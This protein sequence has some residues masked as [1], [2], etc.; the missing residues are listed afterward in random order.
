MCGPQQSCSWTV[1]LILAWLSLSEWFGSTGVSPLFSHCSLAAQ[2]SCQW[3]TAPIS[4]ASPALFIIQYL[5]IH[6]VSLSKS[7]LTPACNQ[8]AILFLVYY[9]KHSK[10][11]ND[12][13][14]S[15]TPSE[16]EFGLHCGGW[17]VSV[18]S[19]FEG[20]VW[21]GWTGSWEGKG[22]SDS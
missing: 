14:Y 20:E 8:T 12:S 3:C 22:A 13:V 11:L 1:C 10:P 5:S 21:G 9:W 18:V 6:N 2:H 16:V 15:Y 7:N 19:L 4:A 17:V